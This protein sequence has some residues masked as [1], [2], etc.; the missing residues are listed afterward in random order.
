MTREP[1]WLAGLKG[2]LIMAAAV[3]T[4]GPALAQ[5]PEGGA[6]DAAW[7]ELRKLDW[8]IGVWSAATDQGSR[9]LNGHWDSGGPWLLVEHAATMPNEQRVTATE[10]IGW[11]PEA[12]VLRS[13]L[14][15][16]DG[17]FST[18]EWMP[19]EGGGWKT[20][21]RGIQPDG[22]RVRA[23]IHWSRPEGRQMT[24]RVTEMTVG[25]VAVPDTVIQMTRERFADEKDI[26]LP[27][28][29]AGR[30][31]AL[32]SIDDVPMEFD[33][34]P[35]FQMDGEGQ[36]QAFGGVNRMGAQFTF[37]EGKLSMGPLRMT[38][39][40]GDPALMAIEA[41]FAEVLQQADGVELD[42]L[43]LVLTR[44]NKPLARFREAR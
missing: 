40:A 37:D 27:E 32:L 8:M 7:N 38:R 39:M 10:R 5:P 30:K 25:G 2:C 20:V 31:W 6:R 3:C 41:K 22:A 34:P 18:S 4:F 26:G 35:W 42:G 44:R 43:E 23:T 21:T 36:L 12:R 24:L 28:G 17:G 16:D 14:F 33:R 15:R 1:A 11:D 29:V 13:W 19:D 9:E